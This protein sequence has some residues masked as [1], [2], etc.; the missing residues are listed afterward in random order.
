MIRS[1]MTKIGKK[2]IDH[3]N[4]VIIIIRLFQKK[5]K[6]CYFEIN[7]ETYQKI[8]SC[9]THMLINIRSNVVKKKYV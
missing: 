8:G 6:I 1:R 4:H 7:L 2:I 9:C 5:C 3:S